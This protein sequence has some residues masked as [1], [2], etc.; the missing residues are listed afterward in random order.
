MRRAM[1]RKWSKPEIKISGSFDFFPGILGTTLAT[2]NPL[3]PVITQG[4][5]VTQRIGNRIRFRWFSIWFWLETLETAGASRNSLYRV[6]LWTPRIDSTQALTYMDSLNSA[7]AVIDTTV[8]TIWKDHT[9]FLANPVTLGGLANNLYNP[10][11][12]TYMRRMYIKFPRNV[13]MNSLIPASTVPTSPEDLM[14]LTL[15]NVAGNAD[16]NLSI[17][18]KVSYTDT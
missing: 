5:G 9:F 10:L 13:N 8:V 14:F 12:Q 17:R 1:A 2:T 4:P 18:W 3:L 11:R 16:T 7:G 6:V 15:Y